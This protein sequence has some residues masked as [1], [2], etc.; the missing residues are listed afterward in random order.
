MRTLRLIVAVLLLAT[1][2][3]YAQEAGTQKTEAKP[4]PAQDVAQ[5]QKEQS[6][7]NEAFRITITFKTTE[8]GKTT[9]Q[10]SYTMVATSGQSNPR[11]GIRDDSRV[12]MKTSPG[13]GLE[14]WMHNGTDVDVLQF[15]MAGNSVLLCLNISTDDLVDNPTAQEPNPVPIARSRHYNVTPTLPV[16]KLVTVYS[17]VDALNNTKVD[18]QVLVE[19]LTAK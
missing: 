19:P 7:P 18:V 16:G 2:L 12:H 1:P 6:P 13:S 11:P 10:R 5:P 17:L 4:A 3:L 8:G 9:T 15:K 14:E